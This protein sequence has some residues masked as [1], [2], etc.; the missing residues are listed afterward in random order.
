MLSGPPPPTTVESLP[1]PLRGV[2]GSFCDLP[3]RLE[4]IYQLDVADPPTM[5]LFGAAN[6]KGLGRPGLHYCVSPNQD[7]STHRQSMDY[8]EE[9]HVERQLRN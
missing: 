2:P 6:Y 1:V 7:S 4:L 9:V 5:N 3:D 8:R